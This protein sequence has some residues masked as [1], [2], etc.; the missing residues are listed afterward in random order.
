MIST[1]QR[2]LHVRWKECGSNLASALNEA[3]H[4]SALNDV[5]LVVTGGV[6][7]QASKMVLASAS[8]FL[9]G[10]LLA[11]LEDDD[12]VIVLA[13]VNPTAMQDLLRFIYF[14]EVSIGPSRIAPLISLAHNLGVDA[15]KDLNPS[16]NAAWPPTSYP[17]PWRL[18][19]TQP[20][21]AITGLSLLATAALK[22]EDQ[23]H[24]NH[25]DQGLSRMTT[26]DEKVLET[27]SSDTVSAMNLSTKHVRDLEEEEE[28]DFTKTTKL[29][30]M[31]HLLNIPDPTHFKW[32]RAAFLRASPSTSPESNGNSIG[33]KIET[34]L[35]RN[36][37]TPPPLAIDMTSKAEPPSIADLP[38]TPSPSPSSL[39]G[40]PCFS[41]PIQPEPSS[42]EESKS[43]IMILPDAF[44]ENL[45]SHRGGNASSQ[46]SNG[47]GKRWKSR[48]PKLCVHC[49]RYFSN[50][51]N[52][53][54][55]ILNMHT[56]GGDVR[57]DKCNKTVKNKWYLRRHQV[58]HHNAPL[59]K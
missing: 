14:G 21:P 50:Q 52:L 46:S 7:F 16:K 1:Q 41:D 26:Y 31:S 30:P 39:V 10:L 17:N 51:F 11:S 36:D 9:K 49:D 47:D 28:E 5:R 29:Y 13:D 59:K 38:A 33:D 19:A 8:P 58:T 25:L 48:Q 54:Q 3:F 15:I 57:C 4:G 55:H 40:T 37:E 32:K 20:T 44:G 2:L 18:A 53:K 27:S 42:F 6:T 45:G 34:M 12:P 35:E 43:P 56:V 22:A 23:P 24:L